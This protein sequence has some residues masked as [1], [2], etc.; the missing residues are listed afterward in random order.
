MTISKT[1]VLVPMYN[2]WKA[3]KIETEIE[4]ILSTNTQYLII[5]VRKLK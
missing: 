5:H 2:M 3:N 1:G 4:T